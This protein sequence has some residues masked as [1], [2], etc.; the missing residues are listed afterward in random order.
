MTAPGGASRTMGSSSN[1]HDVVG[2]IYLIA[3]GVLI[4]VLSCIDFLRPVGTTDSIEHTATFWTWQ[5]VRRSKSEGDQS[6]LVDISQSVEK[7]PRIGVSMEQRG[8]ER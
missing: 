3:D 5:I 6:A 4:L 1:D 2:R 8:T 7:R